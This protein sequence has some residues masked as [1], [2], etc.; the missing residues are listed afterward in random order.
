MS[1]GPP[2][3]ERLDALVARDGLLVTACGRYRAIAEP[4]QGP[5]DPDAPRDRGVIIL[6]D[7]TEVFIEPMDSPAARRSHEE[8]ERF[9]GK[10]VC[11]TGIARKIMPAQGQSLIDPC[12]EHVS[13]ITS[14]RD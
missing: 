9:D 4:R 12:I 1:G 10:R 11:M 3:V 7:G 8:R 14:A 5:P 13:G 6:A 2:V